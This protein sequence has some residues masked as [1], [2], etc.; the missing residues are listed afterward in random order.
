MSEEDYLA[1]LTPLFT[2][3]TMKALTEEWAVFGM[4]E[5]IT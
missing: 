4:T 3:D 1:T 5:R 2:F